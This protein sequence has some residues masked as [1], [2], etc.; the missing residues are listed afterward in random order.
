MYIPKNTYIHTIYRVPLCTLSLSVPR[1]VCL[2]SSKNQIYFARWIGK[3]TTTAKAF[4][5]PLTHNI[6]IYIYIY[7]E[8]LFILSGTMY[9]LITKLH[10]SIILL[11]GCPTFYFIRICCYFYK[12]ESNFHVH[13]WN[14][15]NS[16]Y[17]LCNMMLKVRIMWLAVRA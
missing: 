1:F 5:K 15:W 7:I 3:S 14:F 13:C 2:Q 12:R 4:P 16:S 17:N 11:E 6:Y 8:R 9:W 10:M